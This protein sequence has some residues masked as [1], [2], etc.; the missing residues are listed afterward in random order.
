MFVEEASFSQCLFQELRHLLKELKAPFLH[1]NI[2]AQVGFESFFFFFL[3]CTF[4]SSEHRGKKQG[5]LGWP[6]RPAQKRAKPTV[7]PQ[8]HTRAKHSHKT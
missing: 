6:C 5:R 3:T 4:F 8:L 1:T 7:A 2:N